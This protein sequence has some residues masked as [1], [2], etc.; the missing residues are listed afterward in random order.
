MGLRFSYGNWLSELAALEDLGKRFLTP[1]TLATTLPR[2]RSSL[3]NLRKTD[4]GRLEVPRTPLPVTTVETEG[5]ELGDRRGVPVSARISFVW[6]VRRVEVARGRRG[7]LADE[8]EVVG[9]ASTEVLLYHHRDGEKILTATLQ[10]DLGDDASPGC[11]FHTQLLPVAG[12]APVPPVFAVPRVP[13]LLVTPIDVIVFVLGELFQD[14]WPAS[15]QGN[16]ARVDR[17][18]GPQRRRL[19]SLLQWKLGQIDGPAL[20]WVLLKRAKPPENLF[21]S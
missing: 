6:D 10:A 11:H 2:L 19:E 3:E 5:H 21:V 12:D 14:E 1:T 9:K 16:V 18:R 13:S 7:R 15:L 20:P 4:H 8:F 17:L